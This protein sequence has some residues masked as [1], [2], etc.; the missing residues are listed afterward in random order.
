MARPLTARAGQPLLRVLASLLA[1]LAPLAVVGCG[2]GGSSID[3]ASLPYSFSYPDGFRTGGRSNT[4]ARGGGFENQTIVAKENGQDL[5]AVQTQPLRRQVNARLIPR[6]KREVQQAARRTG[7]VRERSD[8]RIG[9]LDG[10]SLQMSLQAN[11]V[12]VD[13]RWVYAAKDRTLYW[14]NCQWQSDRQAVLRACDQVMRT[15]RAR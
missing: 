4:P 6:V 8:V 7:K 5:V 2:S 11:G 3:D 13:A 9:G 12:P 14:I 10:I 15:F 1:V